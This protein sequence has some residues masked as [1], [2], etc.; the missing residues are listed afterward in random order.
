MTIATISAGIWPRERLFLAGLVDSPLCQ[1]CGE[2]TE[3]D[4]EEDL[5][6]RYWDCPANEHIDHPDVKDTQHMAH[7]GQGALKQSYFSAKAIPSI[8]WDGFRREI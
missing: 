5:V 8:S 1:R 2:G 7:G 3:E 4:V 6:H